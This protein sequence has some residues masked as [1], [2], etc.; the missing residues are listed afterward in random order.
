MNLTNQDIQFFVIITGQPADKYRV[1]QFQGEER[2]SDLYAVDI[3]ITCKPDRG[4][5]P[6][7]LV[8]KKVTLSI[9]H[10]YPQ[11]QADGVYTSPVAGVGVPVRE[12]SGVI[13]SVEHL[14]TDNDWS[15]LRIRLMPSLHRLR[16]TSDCRIF[17]QL[18][19][20]EIV[21]QLLEE[22]GIQEVSV[23]LRDHHQKR[24]YC[25]QYNETHLDFIQRIL[26]EE[27][28]F[29]YY[30]HED[31]EHT[32]V[33]TDLTQGGIPLLPSKT[34]EYNDEPGGMIKA[35][36]VDQFRWK[37]TLHTS[38]FVQRDY[39]FKHPY[40]NQQHQESQHKT[41][42]GVGINPYQK[43]DYHARYKDPEQ[44]RPFTQYTLEAERA[45]ASHG[46]GHSNLP[47]LS[48]GRRF[49]LA[50]HPLDS[51]NSDYLLVSVIHDGHQP[52]ALE[53]RADESPTTYDNTFNVVADDIV[54]W[55]PPMLPKPVIHGTQIAHVVGPKNEEIYTDEY[56][57][58]K[59]HFPWDRYSKQND[60]S[61]CWVR[62][63]QAWAG[64]GWG[65][66]AIPRIGHEVIV[67]FLE[68]DPDQPI[69]IGRTYHEGNPHPYTLPANKTQTGVK[70]RS[71]TGGSAVNFNEIR[72]EDRKDQE[73]VYIHAERNQ[74]NVV[75]HDESTQVGHDRTENVG[76]DETIAIGND[77][78]ESVGH[79]ETISI[80]NDQSNTIG[81]DQ[82]HNITRN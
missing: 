79:D 36:Y 44:G 38:E 2:L 82:H 11:L 63:S 73:Q 5:L 48:A 59:L 78:T 28:I 7:Q 19:V 74:D 40:Y 62:V 27:G 13:E 9:H 66:V 55:R 6:A 47:H 45:Q 67:D 43:Y 1:V 23:N 57:R 50:T 8:D 61:S 26:A 14:S 54:S 15:Q 37:E 22:H 16:H 53:H 29:Y 68:G 41:P 76:N 58:V 42:H 33:L 46:N 30:R 21:Q 80:G 49:T 70:S 31:G 64:K 32:L 17:Q 25:V 71:S 56:G 72:F 3:Q 77:R 39:C 81:N 34:V 69:V 52:Q 10:K 35:Q 65:F 51:Y 18:S 4:L 75:E 20:P 60:T 24:E 12:I